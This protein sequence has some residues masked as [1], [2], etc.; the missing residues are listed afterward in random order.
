MRS[1]TILKP[2]D[3]CG[4]YVSWKSGVTFVRRCFRDVF[5]A[6]DNLKTWIFLRSPTILKPGDFCGL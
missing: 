3:L 1:P 6:S 4:L 5:A 2:G